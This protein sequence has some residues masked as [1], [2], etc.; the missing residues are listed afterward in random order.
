M[1]KIS[2]IIPYYE[3]DSGK[4][5]VLKRLTDSLKGHTEIIISANKGEGYAIPINRG[6]RIAH[7][8]FLVILNDDLILTRG[9]LQSLPDLNAVTSPY[10]DEKSQNFWGCCFCIPRWIYVKMGGLDER[11][12]V[13]YFDDDDFE[14]KLMKNNI[15]YHSV[16]AVNFE[17]VDGGG[18][19]MH[20][21]PD[22]NE[23]F[24][25]NKKRFIEKWGALPNEIKSFYQQYNRFPEKEDFTQTNEYSIRCNN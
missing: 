16:S 13:S 14:M 5:A 15:L 9:S 7:G 3:S 21:F 23:F 8:D 25:E 19:T 12:R 18:R 6:L 22:H 4:P 2:V 10:L 1:H 11:Y 17:N 24:E 20:T